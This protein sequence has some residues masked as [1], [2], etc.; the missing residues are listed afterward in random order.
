MPD[1][2]R[3]VDISTTDSGDF[4]LLGEALAERY[5]Y[6][7]VKELQ[8]DEFIETAKVEEIEYD[9]N[10]DQIL[11]DYKIA[12]KIRMPEGDL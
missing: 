12:C 5:V 4:T 9:D 3:I 7:F 11:V 1:S 2:V 8:N 6:R 10:S